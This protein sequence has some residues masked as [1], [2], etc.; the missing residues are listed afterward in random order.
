M[1]L[2]DQNSD[3]C[4]VIKFRILYK[5]EGVI[6]ET[7][8]T[9]TLFKSLLLLIIA[10]IFLEELAKSLEWDRLQMENL[11]VSKYKILN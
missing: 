1:S 3:L 8:I 2:G 7:K 9:W 5:Y 6:G 10:S 11:L 4:Q